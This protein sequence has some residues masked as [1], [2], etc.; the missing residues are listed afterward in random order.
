M[1]RKIEK[2]I[3]VRPLLRSMEVGEV[4]SLK[5]KDINI[6]SLR[7]NTYLMK[8]EGFVFEI[9]SKYTSINVTIRRVK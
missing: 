3:S 6:P 4:V 8:K 2:K 5:K 9:S 7:T 1:E